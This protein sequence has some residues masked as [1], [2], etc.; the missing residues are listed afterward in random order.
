MS[1][2][3]YNGVELPQLPEWNKT[4]YPYAMLLYDHGSYRLLLTKEPAGKYSDGYFL[5][6]HPYA[7]Y[8]CDKGDTEWIFDGEYI[9]DTGLGGYFEALMFIEWTNHNVYNYDGTLYLAASDPVPVGGEP[10]EPETPTT[11]TE[12]I[13]QDAYKPNTEWNGKTF[14][15]VMGGKWVKQDVVVA[16]NVNWL[17]FSSAEPFTIGVNNATKNWNGTLY[18]STDTTTWSEWDGT[19][20]IASAEH[21]GEQRVYMRG[22]G[23]SVITGYKAGEN[24]KYRWVLTGSNIACNGNIESLLDYKMVANGEHPV[25]ATYCYCSMFY[26]CTALTTAPELPATTLAKNC[27]AYMFKGCTSL[28]TAPA[29]PAT[30][31]AEYCYYSMFEG[32]TALTTSPELPATTLA[33]YCYQEMFSGCK[34]LTTAPELPATTLANDCYS[35]MF[36]Y[37]SALVTLP[38]LPATTLKSY[39]YYYMFY[40]CV[41]IKLSTTQSDEYP[42][43]YRIPTSGTGTSASSALSSMFY[44]TGGSFA[45]TPA[46]N[47]TYYTANEVV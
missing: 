32:C 37:C 28:T 34:S 25:M 5:Y 26:G 8:E 17:T 10:E 3:L 7:E 35:R 31:L 16:K 2:Y 39:C 43:E 36:Y 1:N 24:T 22:S 14:Y 19:A 30:T 15:R 42:N 4:A 23:N 40:G 9:T 44:N 41:S 11:H 6:N 33:K 20:A 46:I 29:L 47:T 38:A 12:W 13:K 18:Y 45:G 21:D 27:Y